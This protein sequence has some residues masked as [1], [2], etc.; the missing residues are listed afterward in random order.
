MVD[1]TYET[2]DCLWI[3]DKAK[4]IDAL[5]AEIETREMLFTN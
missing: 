2:D 5:H 1:V 3:L 4:E